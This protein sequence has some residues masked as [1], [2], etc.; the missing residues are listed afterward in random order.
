MFLCVSLC[1]LDAPVAPAP[2]TSGFGF[3]FVSS[4][5]VVPDVAAVPPAS[6]FSFAQTNAV[7]N[8]APAAVSGFSFGAPVEPA[9]PASRTASNDSVLGGLSFVAPPH[10]AEPVQAVPL[11]PAAAEP[12][13][14]PVPLF[15]GT[16]ALKANTA[17]KK[18]KPVKKIGF[19][20]EDEGEEH[21]SAVS[22]APVK[23]GATS[24]AESPFAGLMVVAES[25]SRPPEPLNDLKA[26]NNSVPGL[27]WSNEP[28]PAPVPAPVSSLLAGLTLKQPVAVVPQSISSHN[29][30]EPDAAPAV[31]GFSFLAPSAH[32]PTPKADTPPPEIVDDVQERKQ[33]VPLNSECEEEIER[34]HVESVVV[35]LQ[36][37]P[38]PHEVACEPKDEVDVEAE[39]EGA[40]SP[41]TALPFIVQQASPPGEVP[42]SS[43]FSFVTSESALP[44]KF[45]VS[46][47]SILEAVNRTADATK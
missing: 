23:S 21:Q 19:A 18:K 4:E 20:R 45:E 1:A 3:S 38:S 37:T 17:I 34:E 33:P 35:S 32:I 8:A 5:P 22:D 15:G 31:T 40:V 13:A 16:T 6:G 11:F 29:S 28:A 47:D 41:P 39:V 25:P 24:A 7:S 30:P 44:E 46:L 12:P 9:E 42:V 2:A 43:G 27:R 36:E 10:V 26:V 14:A